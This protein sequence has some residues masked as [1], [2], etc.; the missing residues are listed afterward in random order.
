MNLDNQPSAVCGEDLDHVENNLKSA[1]SLAK[2]DADR[3]S[4]TTAT[5]YKSQL[6]ED[7]QHQ[8]DKAFL[9]Q[10][11][12]F[13]K[14]LMQIENDKSADSKT[15]RTN[16]DS[17]R[18]KLLRW[19][20]FSNHV[21]SAVLKQHIG[22]IKDR[23]DTLDKTVNLLTLEEHDEKNMT[24]AVGDAQSYKK[25]LQE[26]VQN[27]PQSDR[28]PNFK[29]VIEESPCWEAI[30]EWNKLV[31]QLRQ[32]RI[33]GM[34][35]AAAESQ[36]TA[37]NDVSERFADC[38]EC[39]TLR[40][41]LPYLKAIAHRDNEGERIELPLKK[42]FA[43][44]LV[45]DVWMVKMDD[46]QR[47]YLTAPPEAGK[48][49]SYIISFDRKTR[50]QYLEPSKFE[51][52]KTEHAPQVAVAKQV[53]P[54]LDALNDAN[55]EKSFCK[56]ISIVHA[57]HAMDPILKMNLLQQIIQTGI[58]G[59]YCL[60]NA[61]GRHLEWFKEAKI[62]SF[63]NWLD[64]TNADGA[65]ARKEAKRK[66]DN[67][68]DIDG[69]NKAVDKELAGLREKRLSEYSWIGWLHRTRDGHWECL[70]NR[71]QTGNGTL[72][73]VCPQV[74]RERPVFTVV[75]HLDHNTTTIDTKLTSMLVE[76]RPLYLAVP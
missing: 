49:F 60:E 71:T 57:D 68:P 74:S 41:L 46:E 2:K 63:A 23:Q 59:S 21:S 36:I 35:P 27:N 20:D 13:N 55:W 15:L 64:P 70:M 19:I 51:K 62:N 11:E 25:A 6:E 45:A 65:N 76:G 8:T 3:T 17:Y 72:F 1:N 67:F 47:Y 28:T 10:Y 37:V 69:P 30:A 66:L 7:L 31:M 40:Q 73:V 44:P 12:D 50:I 53:Q 39:T 38:K 29:R 33:V 61:F 24:A 32:I 52:L 48:P 5:K 43:D 14:Q 54:V 9:D 56:M 58:R 42:L 4:I 16:L 18:D 22:A 26:F 34:Q 75:G